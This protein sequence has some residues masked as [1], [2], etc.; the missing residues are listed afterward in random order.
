MTDHRLLTPTPISTGPISRPSRTSWPCWTVPSP[1]DQP[2]SLAADPQGRP[3]RALVETESGGWG[4]TASSSCRWPAA[5]ERVGE[6]NRWSAQ[7]AAEAHPLANPFRHPPSPDSPGPGRLIWPWPWIWGSRG[8]SSTAFCSAFDLLDQR[9]P[10]TFWPKV[11]VAKAGLPV[12]LDTLHGPGLM[13]DQAPSPGLLRVRSSDHSPPRSGPDRRGGR[14]M[15]PELTIIA[16]HHGL[17][18]RLGGGGVRLLEPGQ[19]LL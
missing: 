10:W 16:A 2:P 7:A 18:L 14:L 17:S 15:F 4:G 13:K 8:S 1:R 11:H 6:M 19:R 12:L 5:P 9:N 3:G